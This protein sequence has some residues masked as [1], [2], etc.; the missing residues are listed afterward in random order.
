[1]CSLYSE[2]VAVQTW[3]ETWYC[4]RVHVGVWWWLLF[5]C[6][7]GVCHVSVCIMCGWC[8]CAKMY[9][10]YFVLGSLSVRY[11]LDVCVCGLET[12]SH[13]S[14][15]GNFL[16]KNRNVSDHSWRQGD[17][18]RPPHRL[19]GHPA[20]LTAQRPRENTQPNTMTSADGRRK[21]GL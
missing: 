20:L 21:R 4:C 16:S 18:C 17:T 6:L 11:G 5:I 8:V 14:A 10:V 13:T 2:L 19:C 1:M 12:F 3:G 9:I 15:L 7:P